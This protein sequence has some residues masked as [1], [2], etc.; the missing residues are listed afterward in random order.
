MKAVIMAGGF[1]TRIQPLTSSLGGTASSPESA[2]FRIAPELKKQPIPVAQKIVAGLGLA[3]AI[4]LLVTQ[5]GVA[6]V[7]IKAPDNA[8]TISWFEQVTQSFPNAY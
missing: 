7:W 2:S 5:V 4:A 3:A 8:R 6:N 1:G